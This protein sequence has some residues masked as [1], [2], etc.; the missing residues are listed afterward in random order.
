MKYSEE[1]LTPC[2]QDSCPEVDPGDANDFLDPMA[3]WIKWC[4]PAIEEYGGTSGEFGEKYPSLFQCSREN[5]LLTSIP[6][7]QNPLEI[8]VPDWEAGRHSLSLSFFSSWPLIP[9]D[10]PSFDGGSL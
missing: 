3:D 8:Q 5:V 10:S 7:F 2:L 6:L 9:E 4:S 1:V